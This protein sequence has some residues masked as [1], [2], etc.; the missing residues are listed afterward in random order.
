MGQKQRNSYLKGLE[1]RFL[2]LAEQPHVGKHRPEI[3]EGYY[4]F[5]QH[6]H[7]VFYLIDSDCIHIIGI[8]HKSMDI[9]EYF[10][11]YD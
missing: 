6:Q 9:V 11:D 4:S 3:F 5:P 8:L 7:V 2:F 10:S 1:K